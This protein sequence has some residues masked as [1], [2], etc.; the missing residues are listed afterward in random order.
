MTLPRHRTYELVHDYNIQ[1]KITMIL[2]DAVVRQTFEALLL[3]PDLHEPFR[4]IK[5]L[6]KVL[7]GEE[8]PIQLQYCGRDIR[9]TPIVLVEGRGF[10]EYLH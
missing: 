3:D 4:R 5:H 1:G 9:D 2:R 8:S 10:N 6:N 7:N